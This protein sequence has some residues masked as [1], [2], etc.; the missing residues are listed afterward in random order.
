M[1]PHDLEGIPGP[2][3]DPADAVEGD[4]QGPPP[5]ADDEPALEL[6][7]EPIDPELPHRLWIKAIVPLLQLRSEGAGPSGRVGFAFDQM[8]IAACERLCRIFRSDLDEPRGSAPA[9]R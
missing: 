2:L 5:R 9:G 7:D 4:G 6:A 3:D 8:Y 1:K